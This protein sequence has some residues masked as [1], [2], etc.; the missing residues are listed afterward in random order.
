L[1]NIE[2]KCTITRKYQR[3]IERERERERDKK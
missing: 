3:K 1:H 2:K